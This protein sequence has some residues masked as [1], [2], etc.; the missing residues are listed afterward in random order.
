MQLINFWVKLLIVP[1]L[2][3]LLTSCFLSPPEEPGTVNNSKLAELINVAFD[4]QIEEIGSGR[5]SGFTQEAAKNTRVWLSEIKEIIVQC[6]SGPSNT[7]KTNSLRYHI[8][9]QNGAWIKD[10]YSGERCDYSRTKPLIMKIRF[11]DGRAVEA[12]TDGREKV[13]PVER[14]ARR[15]NG[16]AERIIQEDQIRNRQRYFRSASPDN[17]KTPEQIK[18]EWDPKPK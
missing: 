17:R 15:M 10:I 9:L 2:L 12:L 5:H 11:V 3:T 13:A 7:S 14:I 4:K 1:T 8:G 18:K 6:R 16:F